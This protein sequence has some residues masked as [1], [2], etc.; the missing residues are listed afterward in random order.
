[1]SDI[2]DKYSIMYDK[3]DKSRWWVRLEEASGDWAGIMYSY[4]AFKIKEP[5]TPEGSLMFSFERDILYVPEHLRGKEFPD[6]RNTEFTTLL[7]QIL[8]DIL[9]DN[10][11]KASHRGDRL[12]LELGEDD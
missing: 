12:V 2:K 6:A 5:E 11:D 9:Q 7:G 3:Q 8:Y 10:L 1:M 4:G